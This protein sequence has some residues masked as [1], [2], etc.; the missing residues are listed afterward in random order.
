MAVSRTTKLASRR[1]GIW[2]LVFLIIILATVAMY[3]SP[4][5]SYIDRTGAIARERA[6]TDE[7][8]QQRDSLQTEKVQL[9]NNTYVEQVA[10]RDLG[11]VRP[12]EQPYVVKDL[13]QETPET[14]VTAPAAEEQSWPGRAL[15]YIGSLLP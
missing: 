3:I 13:N 4:I 9:R 7:L 2:R 6:A 11:L 14:T 10:R 1:R 12:G 15:D 8:R 5:R